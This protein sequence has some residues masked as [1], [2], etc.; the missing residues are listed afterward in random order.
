M[1]T[2]PTILALALAAATAA[3]AVAADGRGL[4][5]GF[6]VGAVFP[7]ENVAGETSAPSPSLTFGGRAGAV[8]A[9][10]WTWFVDGTIAEIDSKTGFG[11][12]TE[13]AA[14]SGIEML[15][16]QGAT[17]GWFANAGAGW[18]DFDYERAGSLDFHRPM[19]SVGVGQSIRW[20]PTRRVRWEWR[21]DFALNDSGLGGEGVQQGRLLAGLMWGPRKTSVKAADA[22]PLRAPDT[23]DADGDG[24]RNRN[25]TCAGTP[26]GALVD[27]SGC[28]KDSDADGVPDGIDRCPGTPAGS[29][30]D[31]AGCLTDADGDGVHDGSDA[32]PRTPQGAKVDDFGCPEDRDGDRVPDGVDQ[33]PGTPFGAR[34]DAEGCAQDSDGDGV[35][36]GIDRC[37]DTPAGSPVD[38]SGCPAGD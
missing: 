5:A 19:G 26:A 22:T 38:R 32:C 14:R 13:L 29:G 12:A 21:W 33:C 16:R 34:V 24:V 1:K 10:R 35:V 9:R 27:A 31:A 30:V 18:L 28:P 7:D 6:L 15:F 23:V 2:T 11:Q 20:G 8:F 4:E 37:D 17:L 25:D 36:D 3:P